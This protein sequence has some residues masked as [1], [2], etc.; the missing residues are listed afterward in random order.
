MYWGFFNTFS[1]D[2]T[3]SAGTYTLETARGTT[4]GTYTHARQKQKPDSYIFQPKVGK[5]WGVEINADGSFRDINGNWKV[6]GE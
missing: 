4:S 5:P 2:R 3:T 1:E 6:A